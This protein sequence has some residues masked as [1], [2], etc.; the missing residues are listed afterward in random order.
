MAAAAGQQRERGDWGPAG[1]LPLHNGSLQAGDPHS[2]QALYFCLR[3]GR[4]PLHSIADSAPL[5]CAGS[6]P[7]TAILLSNI[8]PHIHLHPSQPIFFYISFVNFYTKTH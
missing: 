7:D 6:Q 3:D 4:K 5:H 2:G 8:G 1:D